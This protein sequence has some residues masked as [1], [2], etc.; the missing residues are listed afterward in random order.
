MN[1]A[2]VLDG[3]QL[4]VYDL[5]K[6]CRERT[7]VLLDE[8][9]TARMMKARATV[10]RL[11]ETGGVYYGVNTGFGALAD[12]RVEHA[13]LAALQVDLVRSHAVGVQESLPTEIVRG[14]M[15]LRLNTFAKGHSG[16]SASV[17]GLLMSML[18][19]SLHPI[20]PAKG[21]VGASGDLAPLAHIALTLLGE[22]RIEFAGE[23]LAARDALAKAGLMSVKL[24]P[25]DGLALINGTQLMTAIGALAVYDLQTIAETAELV[26]ASAI[27]VLRGSPDAYDSRIHNVRPQAG[28]VESAR[29]L[30]EFIAGSS[31]LSGAGDPVEAGQYPQDPYSIRCVPQVIGAVRDT[32][33]FAKGVIETEM[34][35]A[36]DNPLVFPD[37]GRIISGGNFHGQPVAFVL[38]Y[39]AI[40]ACSVTNLAERQVYRMLD[41]RL[42]NG[43]PSFL[44]LKGEKPG[45]ASGLMAAQYTMAALASENKVLAHPASVDTIPTSAN[46]ED[47]VSMGPIAGLKLR[48]AIHNCMTSLAIALIALSRA[49]EFRGVDKLSEPCR[50]LHE[51]VLALLGE[52]HEKQMDDLVG[53]LV[54]A[55]RKRELRLPR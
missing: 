9:A 41:E 26:S 27:Q 19:H 5:V 46:Y 18:N 24:R 34:N 12:K 38:D 28:Q 43:L 32:I 55:M 37:D 30:R 35:S 2:I 20:V 13:D 11:L 54:E 22:G 29:H 15:A 53:R 48:S 1:N 36:N 52:M 6:V 42:S 31:L 21:S 23:I 25:K 47:F 50:R 39:L 14:I 8:A 17:A 7:P 16:V 10:D 33:R 44:T 3:N 4:T 45:L 40:A 49:A 51:R